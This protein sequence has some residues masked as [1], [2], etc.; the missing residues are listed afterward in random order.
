MGRA[1]SFRT[2]C[3]S[4]GKLMPAKTKAYSARRAKIEM[5]GARLREKV[6]YA[7]R[8]EDF[9]RGNDSKDSKDAATF[10]LLYESADARFCLFETVDKHL[11]AV[12]AIHLV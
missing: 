10:A 2:S 8:C 7:R 4:K 11:N 5:E 1:C 3:C 12:N 9:L 6:G